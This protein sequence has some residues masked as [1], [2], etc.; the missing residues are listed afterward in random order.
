MKRSVEDG[1]PF[2]LVF[3]KGCNNRIFKERGAESL[4]FFLKIFF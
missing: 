2:V 4:L 1:H 3:M